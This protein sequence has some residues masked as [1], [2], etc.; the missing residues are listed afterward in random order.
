MSEYNK[1]HEP[2]GGGNN[3]NNENE[4]NEDEYD[5]DQIDYDDNNTNI[6]NNRSNSRTRVGTGNSIAGGSSATPNVR[7]ISKSKPIM[8]SQQVRV[9]SGSTGVS[10][11]GNSRNINNN[12]KPQNK[13]GQQHVSRQQQ[14]Y[15]QGYMSPNENDEEEEQDD[16][17]I[18]ETYPLSPFSNSTNSNSNSRAQQIHM[19]AQ[20]Q[21]LQIIKNQRSNTLNSQNSVTGRGAMAGSNNGYGMNSQGAQQK[22]QEAVGLS[23]GGGMNPY[24]SSI[25]KANTISS[26]QKQS[27]SG[28]HQSN[29]PD[30]EFFF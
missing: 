6:N 10:S 12:L 7:T 13:S 22:A 2:K 3:N 19:Q 18:D 5:D 25:L 30:G 23:V 4:N 26:L 16:H 27:S 20:Q 8:S 11:L 15:Q 17:A 28:F 1:D 9:G 24:Q 21:K 14:H 29:Y